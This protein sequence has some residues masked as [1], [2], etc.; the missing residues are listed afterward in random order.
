VIERELGQVLLEGS[1]RT[2]ILP[3]FRYKAIRHGPNEIRQTQCRIHQILE[4][5]AGRLYAPDFGSDRVWILYRN[6]TGFEICGWLQCPPGSGSRH[7][8]ITRDGIHPPRTSAIELIR[9]R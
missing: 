8:V 3:A 4:D 6:E 1:P 9:L 7:A 2:E 5:Q